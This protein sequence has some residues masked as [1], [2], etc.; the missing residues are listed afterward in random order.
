MFR[1]DKVNDIYHHLGTYDEF[2]AC[3]CP[4]DGFSF[5]LVM[6]NSHIGKVCKECEQV[7]YSDARHQ[8]GL[9]VMESF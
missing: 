2:C 3:G 7:Q 6:D 1:Y 5:V 8:Y 4:T 9:E